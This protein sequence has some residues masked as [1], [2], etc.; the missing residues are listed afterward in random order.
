KAD[1]AVYRDGSGAPDTFYVLPSSGGAVRAQNFGD[2]AS[3]FIIPADFD[4]DGKTDYAVWRGGGVGTNGTWYWLR[5]SD[6]AFA[7]QQFGLGG[8][9]GVR[10]LPVPGD[11]DGDG[12]TDL[13]VWRPGAPGVFYHLGLVSGFTQAPFGTTNDTPPAF[14]LQ[15]R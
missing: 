8:A 15:T 14:T 10:D 12:K 2:F 11:Y 3:D 1:I 6:G 5:S 4:G 7:G 13:A 9:F